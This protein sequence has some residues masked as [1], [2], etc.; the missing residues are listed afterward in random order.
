MIS[1][2]TLARYLG[3]A[4]ADLLADPPFSGWSFVRTVDRDLDEPPKGS[5]SARMRGIG[6]ARS[7][8]GAV[9]GTGLRKG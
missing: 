9:P 8:S 5:M 6:L 2:E 7:L 3:G 4:A 1:T